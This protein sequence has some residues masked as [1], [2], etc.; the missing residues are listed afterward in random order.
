MKLYRI[1][2]VIH[3]HI[4]LMTNEPHRIIDMVY[5]SLM[6]ILMWGFT[7]IWLQGSADQSTNLSLILLTSLVL[8]QVLVRTQM[9]VSLC[10]LEELWSRNMVNLFSTPL[11][12]REWIGAIMSVSFIKALGIALFGFAMVWFFFYLSPI[13]SG[14]Y[15]IPFFISLVV[16]GW[17]LGFLTTMILVHTGQSAQS[18]AWAMGW[19]IAPFSSVFYPVSILPPWAQYIAYA[20]PT[21]YTFESIRSLLTTGSI[22]AHYW[23][24]GILLNFLYIII[25]ISMFTYVFKS[26]KKYGLA[27]LEM[28]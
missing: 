22:P 17:W 21:T 25:I 26:S 23:Y 5:W 19:I 8:W 16:S 14:W 2:A 1:T 12:I 11:H 27:R 9:E 10:L 3:R 24:M 13:L 15:L 6:D 18:L 4:L 28:E 7:S 20:L